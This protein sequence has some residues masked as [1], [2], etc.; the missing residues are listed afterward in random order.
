MQAVD[1]L[2]DHRRQL[3]LPLPAG[4]GKVGR[5]RHRVGPQHPFTVKAVEFRRVPFK[6]VMTDDGLRRIVPVFAVK[7]AGTAEIGNP[8]LGGNARP[9]EK[10]D[11]AAVL[12]P[13][14]EL[15]QLFHTGGPPLYSWVS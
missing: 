7:T 12:H 8:A 4:E 2:G 10:N 11:A 1:I 9:T 15:F 6:K 3:P 14:F 13:A 5:V